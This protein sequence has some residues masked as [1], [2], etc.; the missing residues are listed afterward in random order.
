MI[1]ISITY[2]SILFCVIPSPVI[3]GVCICYSLWVSHL[4]GLSHGALHHPMFGGLSWEARCL[5]PFGKAVLKLVH[6]LRWWR[7]SVTSVQCRPLAVQN[8][9]CNTGIGGTAGIG[10]TRLPDTP[11]LHSSVGSVWL[12]DLVRVVLKAE[13]AIERNSYQYL[14]CSVWQCMCTSS[15]QSVEF[16]SIGF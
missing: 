4:S 11:S 5:A 6:Q 2:P 13:R 9:I 3:F 8:L 1:L 7:R 16:D 12:A 15:A 14:S 10:S